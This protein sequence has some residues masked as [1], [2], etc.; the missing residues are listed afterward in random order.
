ML[1]TFQTLLATVIGVVP[2][3]V[4][5]AAF[6]SQI[7][8]GRSSL[9]DRLTRYV[10]TSA[11]LHAILAPVTYL[12]FTE[13]VSAPETG[14]LERSFIW[15]LAPGLLYAALPALVGVLSATV[16]RNTRRSLLGQLLSLL[17]ARWN[18]K[19]EMSAP[20]S[21]D[22]VL[23]GSGP[24]FIR[25]RLRS[26]AWVAGFWGTHESRD[27]DAHAAL[28]PEPRELFLPQVADVD[29][30]GEFLTDARG[31]VQLRDEGV[32]VRWDDIDVLKFTYVDIMDAEEGA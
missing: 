15:A 10:T 7:G 14:L 29:A 4:Y 26:G 22:H 3:A 25:A 11:V 23:V 32:L 20:S 5:V 17:P 28:Y 1:S 12:L 31:N 2:G 9:P 8:Q 13:A 19:T 6:D 24:A 27:V 18:L 16:T 21:W 30:G